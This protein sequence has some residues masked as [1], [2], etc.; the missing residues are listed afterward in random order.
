MIKLENSNTSGQSAAHNRAEMGYNPNYKDTNN[1][2][3][4]CLKEDLKVVKEKTL[5]RIR[6]SKMCTHRP[7]L[8]PKGEISRNTVGVMEIAPKPK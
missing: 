4:N 6:Q 1:K 8:S 3:I 2:Y 5:Y 7:S